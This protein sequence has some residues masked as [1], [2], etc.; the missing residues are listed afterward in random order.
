MATS[1]WTVTFAIISIVFIVSTIVFIYLYFT[2]PLPICRTCITCPICP[3]G[4]TAS[5]SSQTEETFP[6]IPDVPNDMTI[7]LPGVN[8]PL[9]NINSQGNYGIMIVDDKTNI[10]I[11]NS[12]NQ[13]QGWGFYSIW[14]VIN[15]MSSRYSLSMYYVYDNQ[16]NELPFFEN[17][18][19]GKNINWLTANPKIA[20]PMYSNMAISLLI[21]DTQTQESV[22]TWIGA[23]GAAETVT[24]IV[25]KSGEIVMFTDYG[26][27]KLS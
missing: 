1:G 11:V 2:K 14:Q 12:K 20:L 23:P 18:S 5:I 19:G 26:S 6:F 17:L 13:N 3:T 15:Y 4:T 16:Y 9:G 24:I 25:E 7:G 27:Y 8:F 10:M 21:T 22:S